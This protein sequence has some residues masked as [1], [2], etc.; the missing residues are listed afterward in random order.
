MSPAVR[1]IGTGVAVNSAFEFSPNRQRAKEILAG[2]F[3]AHASI[4][5]D[6][7]DMRKRRRDIYRH[8]RPALLDHTNPDFWNGKKPEDF[9]GCFNVGGTV[10]STEDDRLLTEMYYGI[11]AAI[12]V[13]EGSEFTPVTGP[14]FRTAV[15]DC[16]MTNRAA[17]WM[18]YVKFK[19]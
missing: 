13:S 17:I 10:H 11:L 3:R 16:V 12:G 1:Y 2:D 8:I 7:D 5:D 6:L 15:R 18:L 19:S 14:K 4:L 9:K